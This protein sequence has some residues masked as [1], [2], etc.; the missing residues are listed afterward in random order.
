MILVPLGALLYKKFIPLF[1]VTVIGANPY[2]SAGSLL[3]SLL[4]RFREIFKSKVNKSILIISVIWLGYGLIVGLVNFSMTFV[5]EYIQLII[6]ILLVVYIYNI[7]NTKKQLLIILKYIMISGLLLS[8]FEIFIFIANIDTK[9]LSFIGRVPDNYTAF[10][11]VIST[12][13]LPLFFIKRNKIS[14][15]I[16]PIGFFAIYINESRAMMLL[17]LLFISKSLI[18]FN[19]KYFKILIIGMLLIILSYIYVNFDSALI[20]QKKSL[21]SVL[22]FE[23]NYSNLERLNLLFYSYELFNNNSF[24]YGLGASHEIFTNNPLT[25]AQVYSHPHNTIAFLAVELGIVGILLYIC[26]FNSMIKSIKRVNDIRFKKITLDLTLALFLYSLVDALFYNGIL[27][28]IVFML[29]G[30]VLSAQKIDFQC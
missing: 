10:Y 5:S 14:I 4:I 22:N 16:I 13:I 7:I 28:L 3:L 8:V 21:Y 11:L 15:Y 17:A 18:S 30:I 23:N 6:S 19:K 29:Y 25:I 26:F 1:L 27:M 2:I 24:G 12:I 20:Y 9:T